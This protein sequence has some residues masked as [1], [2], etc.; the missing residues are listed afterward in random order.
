[1]SS[2][3]LNISEATVIALHALRLIAAS[4]TCL[5]SADIASRARV[6]QAHL[7]KVLRKLVTAG[8]LSVK[9]GPAGG[10]YLT[11]EQAGASFME[12]YELFDGKCIAHNCVFQAGPCGG[13]ECIFGDFISRINGEF[14]KFFTKTKIS[15]RKRK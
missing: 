14:V 15:N 6:S 7:S 12:V 8:M 9:R 1:M 3:I 11:K 2:R 10:F 4:D 5:N 13:K